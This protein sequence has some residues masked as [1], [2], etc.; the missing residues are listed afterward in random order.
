[1]ISWTSIELSFQPEDFLKIDGFKEK[2]ANKIYDNIQS[3]IVDADMGT[4]MTASNI[5]GHG[6][7]DKKLALICV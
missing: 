4:V 5:F 2:M 3:M 6:L 1:M 7:G